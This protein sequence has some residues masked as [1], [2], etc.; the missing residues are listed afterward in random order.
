MHDSGIS[1]EMIDE[2]KRN[3][4]G[5]IYKIDCKYPDGDNIP[6]E[7]IEGAWRVNESGEIF[8]D[9]VKNDSYRPI[10][11]SRRILPEFMRMKHPSQAHHWMIEFDLRCLHLFPKI[12]KEAYVGYWLISDD[13]APNGYFRPTSTYDPEAVTKILESIKY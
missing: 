2:A 10:E 9:F 5:W 1:Q 4:N 8:G 3:P 13:G 7:A 12:P 11:K 6:P